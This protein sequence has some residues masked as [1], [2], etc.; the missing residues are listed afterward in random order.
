MK[1]TNRSCEARRLS[2]TRYNQ[3]RKRFEQF[4]FRGFGSGGGSGSSNHCQ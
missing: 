3:W 1:V 2:V 4:R